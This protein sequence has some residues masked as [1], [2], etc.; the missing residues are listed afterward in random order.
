MLAVNS[1]GASGT[2][3]S[4]ENILTVIWILKENQL[5]LGGPED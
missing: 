5:R 1:A 3:P 4:A 2:V